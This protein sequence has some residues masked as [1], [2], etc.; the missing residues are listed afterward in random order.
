VPSGRNRWNCL[1]SIIK[2]GDA[3][4][5]A[6]Y[7]LKTV[8][9]RYF[10]RLAL[11]LSNAIRRRGPLSVLADLGDPRPGFEA[12]ARSAIGTPFSMAGL[13]TGLGHSLPLRAILT[14]VHVQDWATWSEGHGP[15]SDRSGCS[16]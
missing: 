12:V 5:S 1:V 16:R 11:V 3:E 7:S 10:D 8:L 2:S 13:L 15:P 6:T 14:S 4:R 9:G